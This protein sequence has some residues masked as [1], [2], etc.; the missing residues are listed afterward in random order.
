MPI[1]TAP[2]DR[3][4]S[5]TNHVEKLLDPARTGMECGEVTLQSHHRA[6][7]FGSIDFGGEIDTGF[8]HNTH[9]VSLTRSLFKELKIPNKFI[10]Y[11][12]RSRLFDG[13]LSNC[14][15]EST[16]RLCK[17]T[18]A[19]TKKSCWVYVDNL[20]PDYSRPLISKSAGI[21]LGLV[22]AGPELVALRKENATIKKRLAAM[23][24]ENATIKKE[25]A[26]IK[27]ENATIKKRLAA[28]Q[29][30]NATIKKE[31]ATIKKRLAAMQ[32]ENAT[33]K[34]EN[35]TIKKRLAAMQ[36]ENATIKK[37]NAT[38]KKR[39]AALEKQMN[40]AKTK[41]RVEPLVRK[42]GANKRRR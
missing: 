18:S 8:N 15:D 11:N 2:K 14:F 7:V 40:P 17:L 39:L 5:E 31:N 13:S 16:S 30:E 41:R 35:A 1:D 34:K 12:Q 22:C 29:K 9:A 36:K 23:Q 24:K 28:M 20:R 6:K 3:R 32:K 10:N 37:E 38:I 21:V 4:P 33:I 19:L 25:N 26:T 27:K 42:S